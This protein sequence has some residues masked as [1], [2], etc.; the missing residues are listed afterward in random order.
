MQR[1]SSGESA[2]G[3]SARYRVGGYIAEGTFGAVY[4]LE[5]VV[6]KKDVVGKDFR[7]AHENNGI[8]NSTLHELCI[9]ARLRDQPNFVKLIEIVEADPVIPTQE[10]LLAIMERAK[11]SLFDLLVQEVKIDGQDSLIAN[12]DYRPSA[13]VIKTQM[14]QLLTA[15]AHLHAIGVVHTDLKPENVLLDEHNDVRV[16]DF[17]LSKPY[18]LPLQKA[19]PIIGTIWWQAPELL[20]YINYVPRQPNAMFETPDVVYSPAVDIWAVGTIM[21]ELFTA[22]GLWAVSS[23]DIGP[24]QTEAQLIFNK[25][26]YRLGRPTEAVW[27]GITAH[28]AYPNYD[29]WIGS[30]PRVGDDIMLRT[31][32]SSVVMVGEQQKISESAIDLIKGML[33]WDPSRRLTAAEALEHPYFRE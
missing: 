27:P 21:V 11:G 13:V 32:L 6:D 18:A 23:D 15:V 26:V 8:E 33:A 9:M 22:Y 3:R 5:D 28:R 10:G 25:I 17:G 24:D 7:H 20:L 16:A 30:S 31:L 29:K 14:F 2:Y 12:P 4:R 1:A 19:F